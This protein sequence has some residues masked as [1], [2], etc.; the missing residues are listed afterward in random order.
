[1]AGNTNENLKKLAYQTVN[2]QNNSGSNSGTNIYNSYKPVTAAV[3]REIMRRQAG[4]EANPD[5]NL[6]EYGLSDNSNAQGV[7]KESAQ[8]GKTDKTTMSQQYSNAQNDVINNFLNGGSSYYNG[9]LN[10][11]APEYSGKYGDSIDNTVQSILNYGDY[12]QDPRLSETMDKILGGEDFSYDLNSDALYSNYKDQYTRAAQSA[13]EGA[14]GRAAAASG[15]FGNSYASAAAQQS[16][17]Q[18]MQSLGNVIPELYQLA[19]NSY[20]NTR[21]D[22]YNQYNML[23][24]A[25][26]S[27]Y[28]RYTDALNNLY[29]RQSMLTNLENNDYNR[30]LNELSQYNT[31]R[32]FV[33]G[34]G[35]R[36]S[37]RLQTAASLMDNSSDRLYNNAVVAAQAGNY[38]LLSDYLG[39]DMS[40]AQTWDKI[41]KGMELYS[42]TGIV[43]FLQ[44][45]GL[46]TTRLEEQMQDEQF[47]NKLSAAISIYEATGDSKALNELD[48]DTSYMDKIMQYALIQAQNEANGSSGGTGGTS[49]SYSGSSGKSV[50]TDE[51]DADSQGN[52]DNAQSFE[53]RFLSEKQWKSYNSHLNSSVSY[54]SFVGD[55][56]DKAVLSGEITKDEYNYLSNKYGVADLY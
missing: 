23:Q 8:L 16:Y 14:M 12:Q 11:E 27:A 36:E 6:A 50:V 15:G 46:D 39:V 17:N 24:S 56:L 53:A 40:D 20:L 2:E 10:M 45:A 1:M 55:K 34:L 43:S 29:N 42:S 4:Y 3:S 7:L 38:S 49:C 26:E 19:Y 13:A 5:I 35:D 22:D 41:Q 54:E 32:D 47:N 9:A 48:I 33:L 28:G 51:D 52:T 31:D 21:Q 25:D 18:Q 44:A 37:D 30:Y